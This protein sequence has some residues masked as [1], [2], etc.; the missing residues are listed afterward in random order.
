MSS[1]LKEAV[2]RAIALRNP[3][4]ASLFLSECPEAPANASSVEEINGQNRYWRQ[5]LEALETVDTTTLREY[6]VDGHQCG[7]GEWMRLFHTGILPAIVAFALPRSRQHGY[8]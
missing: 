6:L 5:Q 1:P 3:D 8:A 2:A 4:Q 7:I